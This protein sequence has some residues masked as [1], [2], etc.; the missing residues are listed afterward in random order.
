MLL[1][2]IALVVYDF[3]AGSEAL[4][5]VDDS[6]SAKIFQT[7]KD[8]LTVEIADQESAM[9]WLTNKFEGLMDA[10]CGAPQATGTNTGN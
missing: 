8:R 10:S 4:A 9:Q 2:A 6:Q 3:V 1:V 7:A 5:L